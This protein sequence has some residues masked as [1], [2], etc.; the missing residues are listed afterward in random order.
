MERC[1]SQHGTR[2]HCGAHWPGLV[3]YEGFARERLLLANN[4]DEITQLQK[5][6][7]RFRLFGTDVWL[8][9]VSA[10]WRLLDR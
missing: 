8:M 3:R 5:Y 1:V 9:I 7:R 10:R 4:P 6:S 2:S